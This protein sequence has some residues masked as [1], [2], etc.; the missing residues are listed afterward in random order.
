MLIAVKNR[1]WIVLAS[2]DTRICRVLQV[3]GL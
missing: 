3:T 2:S 1:N